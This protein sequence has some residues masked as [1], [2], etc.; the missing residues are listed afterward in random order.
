VSRS[1]GRASTTV[2]QAD[3]TIAAASTLQIVLIAAL[4]GDAQRAF[5]LRVTV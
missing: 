3:P 2:W 1:P 4:L 5:R